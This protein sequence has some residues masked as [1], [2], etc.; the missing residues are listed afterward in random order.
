MRS[1]HNKKQLEKARIEIEQTLR[2]RAFCP[3]V[4]LF[5]ELDTTIRGITSDQAEERLDKFGENVIDTGNKKGFFRRLLSS[6]INPFNSVLAVVAVITVIAGKLSG[7][8]IDWTT[9]III[10]SLILLSGAISFWQSERG[11]AAADKLFHLISNNADIWR[12]GELLEIS[13]HDIVPG[14]IVKLAAGDI[15]PGD[16]RFLSTKDAFVSQSALTGESEPVEKFSSRALDPETAI[17]DISN[18][19]FMGC[20]MISGTATA[21]VLSTGNNTYFGSMASSISGDRAKNSFEKGV[22]SVSRLLILFMLIMVPVIFLVNGIY[23]GNWIDAFLF[24]VSIAVGMT[25]EMLP[26]I[27][28][29]TLAKG[30]VVMSKQ[31][32][33]VKN[34]SAIQ[35]FGQ[36]DILCTDK[37][38]TLTQ[39]K[40]VL[41][42]YMDIQGQED[43][44]ILR[45]SFLNSYFQTGLKNLIDLA[46]IKRADENGFSDLVTHYIRE[47]EIPFD[48]TR[49]RMSVV[50]KD[51]KGKRQLITKGA[52]HEMIDICTYAEYNGKIV[53]LDDTLRAEV[54]KVV[55]HEA[56]KGLRVLAVAQ[57]N[58]VAD[59]ETFGVAD[60]ND[61]VL[62]GFVGFLDPPKESAKGAIMTLAKH[63]VRTVVLTGD[64]EGVARKV[65]EK[66]GVRSDE[67][68]LGKDVD[69]L[70]DEELYKKAQSCD[71]FAKLS[72]NQK[73]RII[74][75]L[76]ANGH[77][78]GYM[79]DGINDAPALRQSDVGISVDSGVEIA[80]E[81]ADIIL[82]KKDLMVLERGVFFGRQTFGNIIKYIKLATSGN[83]G[84]MFSILVASIFLQFLPLLPIHIILQNLL[85]DFSQMGIPFD[86]VDKEYL[87]KPRKW[88]T[89]SISR[90]MLMFGPVSSLVDILCFFVLMKV[91]DIAN[92]ANSPGA[93]LFQAGWFLFGT[94]SQVLILH[95][96]RSRKIPFLQSR[97]SLPLLISTIVFTVVTALVVFTNIAGIFSF[98][99]LP[100]TII[101]WLVVLLFLYAGV[102]QLMKVVYIKRYGEWL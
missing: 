93:A 32:V 75:V 99:V 5:E 60:E 96:I 62:I 90:F 39:D 46:I 30:A 16:V 78:V 48:F 10:L 101:P 27:M 80:K 22:N 91:L 34:L 53:P 97:A 6:F 25:P 95:V 42:K 66:V 37:T 57:K 79:G 69:L 24:A 12:D 58:D 87:E 29:S 19:G 15:I 63:G 72:P 68:L 21:V 85:C 23:K 3:R 4:D 74:S 77:T 67:L 7:E 31:Q 43:E 33:I 81:T 54:E 82:L 52:S 36:M 2:A 73:E 59:I 44:R 71:I 94:I 56:A 47:D 13:T 11:N 45:H 14:D 35:T 65:C 28:T 26:M 41:E 83:F 38:G 64:S 86:K 40:I 89:K 50:L 51:N 100:L 49:R 76:Q 92:I 8:G 55:E 17:T 84:N 9:P 18:I 20:N 98:S 1:Q 88:E 61:M 70:S 102:A